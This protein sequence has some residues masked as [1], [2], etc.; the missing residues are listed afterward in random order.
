VRLEKGRRHRIRLEWTKE[1]GVETLR[2]LWK[3]PAPS[4]A[5]SLWSEVG[6]GIDYYFM[7]GPALDKVIAGYRRV[8]G[9]APMMPVWAYGFWQ[10]RER[11]KTQQEKPGRPREVPRPRGADRQRGAGLAV[12]EG[13]FLGLAPVRPERFPDPAG[14]IREIHDK[15]H[16]RLMISVWGSS[17]R[18]TRNYDALHAKGL[19]FEQG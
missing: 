13:R 18:A 5:T 14:W 15:W 1:Q 19:L 9:E 7:Y 10:C 2:L 12:L 4:D 16:A 6:D 17:T 3:T 11:Y 8:T